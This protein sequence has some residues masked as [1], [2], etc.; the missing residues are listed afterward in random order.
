MKKEAN[1]EKLDRHRKR[2]LVMP[3]V[4]IPFLALGFHALGGGKGSNN[5]AGSPK[6]LNTEVPGVTGEKDMPM[7]KLGLYARAEKDSLSLAKELQNDPYAT[8]TP[9]LEDDHIALSDSGGAA[10]TSRFST[11]KRH[12]ASEQERLIYERLNALNTALKTDE[13]E[14]KQIGIQAEQAGPSVNTNDIDRLEAMMNMMQQGDPEDE[15]MTA[16]NNTL[17]RILDI[18]HPERVREKLKE[19][20]REHLGR[21]YAVRR[22]EY[23]PAITYLDNRSVKDY[24]MEDGNNEMAQAAFYGLEETKLEAQEQNA[25]EAVIHEGQVVT[26]GSTV[27]LRLTND[28]LINGQTVP[29]GS[30]VFG[31]ASLRGERLEIDVPGIRKG[32][33][34]FPV[35][36]A[37][38]DLDGLQG[39]RIPGAIERDVS[40][41]SGDQALGSLGMGIYDPSLGAQAASAGIQLGKSLLS[42]KIKLVRVALKAGYKV[43]LLDQKQKINQ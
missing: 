6:G 8:F 32:N 16:I 39:I 19:T 4:I 27:K 2:L 1:R 30:F 34:L 14:D 5:L 7:D 13:A 25:I 9:F 26:T 38:Y 42:K 37:V 20:S 23:E 3:I 10:G 24:A 11:S 33:S 36:L 17:E 43:L 41:Q 40:K 31:T 18:Q 29:A 12:G 35:Q 21:V 15:E 28:I 22:Q